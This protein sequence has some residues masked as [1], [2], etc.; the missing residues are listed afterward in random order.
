M[1]VQCFIFLQISLTSRLKDDNWGFI[2]S[3]AVCSCISRAE[4]YEE[5]QDTWLEKEEVI[6]TVFLQPNVCI[7]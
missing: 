4:A 1:K 5:Y 2:F 3:S 7:L 6:S